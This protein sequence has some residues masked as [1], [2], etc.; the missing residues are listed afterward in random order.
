MASRLQNKRRLKGVI[1]NFALSVASY[2]LMLLGLLA[3]FVPSSSI[4]RYGTINAGERP[5]NYWITIAG[6]FLIGTIFF[7]VGGLALR[8]YR[9]NAG[10]R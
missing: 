6:L 3:G 5:I 1:I 8:R 7:I 9:N 4:R 2:L 10:Q